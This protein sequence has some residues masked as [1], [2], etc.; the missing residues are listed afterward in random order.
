MK[1]ALIITY[2]W[3]PA[4]GPGVQRWLKFVKY[5]R[6]FGWEPVVYTV[7]NPSYPIMDESLYKEIPEGVELLKQPI[8]EPYKL[9]GLLTS[10]K[11]IDKVKGGFISTKEKQNTFS[12]ITTWVRGN[13]F[14]PDARKFWVKPSVKYLKAYLVNNDIDIVITTGPPHSVHLIGLELKKLLGIKWIADF[15]DPWTN[16][17]YYSKLMLTKWADRKHH[18]LERDVIESA[19][20]ILIVSKTWKNELSHIAGDKIEVVTNGY[21]T[22]KESEEDVV[23]D[24]KFSI[25]HIG[26]MNADRN[27]LVLWQALRECLNENP[28]LEKDI[29][30][31]LAGSVS[32]EVFESLQ[33][34]DLD[35]YVYH[36]KYLS[37]NDVIT[38]QKKSQVLLLILN[39]TPNVMGIVPGK[40]FE[41]LNAKR[42]ILTIGPENGDLSEI[43][44]KTKGGVV[45]DYHKKDKMKVLIKN[46]FND[47]KSG[48]LI[49]DS[50]NLE[51]YSRRNITGQ[52]AEI[53][54]TI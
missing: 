24:S 41:Y 13:F 31:K 9:A 37:H 51:S 44:S 3:P 30:V 50:N 2:Y 20:K 7:E 15:R 33:D 40:F 49:V 42:P 54:N 21:D 28:E 27:P 10:K 29:Q 22:E 34:L 47:F 19:D 23:L 39:N 11:E 8:F 43:L 45:I 25:A 14:I 17:D 53:M 48:K 26:S 4:G 46:Y 6:D 1:K 32:D 5:L 38:F 36:E 18:K 16:I 52:L 35:K 12:K